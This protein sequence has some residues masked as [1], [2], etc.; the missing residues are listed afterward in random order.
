MHLCRSFIF[1][2]VLM[3]EV[4]KLLTCL[5]LVFYENGK[6]AAKFIDS[7][8][9]TVIKNY[10]DTI[11]ICVPSL[12]YVVQN[13][14]L[15]VSASHLDA[16]TYQVNIV[17]IRVTA[18]LFSL[19]NHLSSFLCRSAI[20]WKFL[21]RPFLPWSSCARNCW[22]RN[23]ALYSFWLLASPSCRQPNPIKWPQSIQ[24]HRHKIGCSA[25][26]Q[27]SVHA[28]YPASLVFTSRKCWKAPIFLCGCEMCSWA[29][30]AY[31]LALLLALSTIMPIYAT[32]VSLSAT[33]CLFGI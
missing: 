10:V 17:F 29:C 28:S 24:M 19:A 23:G 11:K 31:R 9:T 22:P 26:P 21:P 32:K 15:Y 3:A 1:A 30:W 27:R 20:S 18:V 33:T 25:L 12:L 6:D 2:A 13:N 5:V 14:L 16:A 8:H 4:V 7:L